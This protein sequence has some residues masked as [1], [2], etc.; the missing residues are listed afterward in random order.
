MQI[1]IKNKRALIILICICFIF[2]LVLCSKK[3]N[4]INKLNKVKI[5]STLKDF[6]CNEEDGETLYEERK[7]LDNGDIKIESPKGLYLFLIK[8]VM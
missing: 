5:I 6:G 8:K 7:N 3:I 4:S 2:L 1:T